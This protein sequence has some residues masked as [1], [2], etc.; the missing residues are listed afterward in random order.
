MEKIRRKIFFWT[1][2]VIFFIAAPAII[3]NARGYRFD[4]SRGVF[5]YSGT[6]TVKSNPQ[7]V[8]INLNGQPASSQVSRINNSHNISGLLPGDYEIVANLPGFKPWNKK[9]DI[10]SGLA[11][12]FWNVLLI[13]ENYERTNYQDTAG[14]EK[15]YVSPKDDFIATVNNQ[16]GLKIGIFNISDK[17]MNADFPISDWKFIDDERK[18][19]IEWSP[20]EK[21]IS[22][23]VQKENQVKD[24]KKKSTVIEKRY[25][26]FIINPNDKISFNLN[27]LLEK[28]NIYDVRWDPKDKNYVFFLEG[29]NL[30]RAN[31]IDKNDIAL[32]SDNVSAYDLSGSSVYWV[33]LPNDMIFKSGTDG[34]GKIQITNNFP[35]SA[36]IPINKIIVYDETRIGL[37]NAS[38]ELFIY[39]EG[40]HDTYFRKIGSDVESLAFSDDGKKTLFWSDNEILVYFDRDWN[41]QPTRSEN[42][43][44]GI[45]R[46][47]EKIYNVGWLRDY[48]HIIF[49][50]NQWVKVIEVDGRDKRNC[51]DL[52]ST[53]INNPFIRYNNSLEYLFFTDKIG[54]NITLN[55]IIFP[56]PTPILGIGG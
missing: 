20:D 35:G 36:E 44:S 11:S 18:E 45:T 25:N 33:G 16:D 46:Y 14:I 54:E 37:I 4:S 47:S 32:I 5:V 27:E 30:W 23:P 10:H 28:E 9:T 29:Q 51:Q 17:K 31:V 26:Y 3:L 52:I 41:V 40:D 49:N 8:N 34:S 48:E 1:L 6:I 2:V 56:E 55:S 53:T 21:Y 19:N 13:K 43:L 42:E 12:E 22:V 7:T 15:F 24:V 39:N 50:T 38:K